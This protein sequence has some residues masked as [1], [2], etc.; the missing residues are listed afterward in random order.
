[1]NLAI[2]RWFSYIISVV[3]ALYVDEFIGALMF[4]FSVFLFIPSKDLVGHNLLWRTN[5]IW[6]IFTILYYFGLATYLFYNPKLIYDANYFLVILVFTAPF[7]PDVFVFE[8]S[9]YMKRRK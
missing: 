5:L 8:Y 6:G 9:D 2:I 4:L 1:M 7:V 3:F